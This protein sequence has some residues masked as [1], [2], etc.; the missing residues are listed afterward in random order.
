MTRLDENIRIKAARKLYRDMLKS[1][2]WLDV[3]AKQGLI[4]KA[5]A[6]YIMNTERR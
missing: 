6:V 4:T 1:F 5:E 3:M 2:Y